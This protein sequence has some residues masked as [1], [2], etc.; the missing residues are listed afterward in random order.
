MA[1]QNIR[2]KLPYLYSKEI[3]V[4]NPKTK[5]W[6]TITTIK[7]N[8]SYKIDLSSR[9]GKEWLKSIKEASKIYG[10]S[11]VRIKKIKE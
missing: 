10:S 8:S 7:T 1:Y 11:N 2:V 6:G 5:K 9:E 4:K 3:Q